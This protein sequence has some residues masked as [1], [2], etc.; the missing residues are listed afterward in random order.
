MWP[1]PRPLGSI[2]LVW[3]IKANIHMANPPTK[4][5]V[6]SFGHF[7]DIL[8]VNIYKKLSY[9]RGTA[10]CV[11]SVKISPTATQQCSTTSPEQIEVMKLEG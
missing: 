3:Y 10:Q 6:S 7:R 2:S 1:W 8:G 9:R 5:E 4:F 11:V